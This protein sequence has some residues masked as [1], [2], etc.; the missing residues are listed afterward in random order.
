MQYPLDLSNELGHY[1]L[2][3]SGFVGY[4]AQTSAFRT[5]Q[6]ATTGPWV[7]QKKGKT[8]TER[9]KINSK[10][11]CHSITT[12]GIALYMLILLK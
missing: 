5:S 11:T 7:A 8:F 6:Q 10:S 3:E 1:I 9:Q 12:S 2:F 4:S